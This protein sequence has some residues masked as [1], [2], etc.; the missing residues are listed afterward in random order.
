LSGLQTFSNIPQAADLIEI[1]NGN[2]GLS[3]LLIL[4]N[5][6]PFLEY[7]M[8]NGQ[9]LAVNVGKA[10]KPGNNNTIMLIGIGFSPGSTAAVDIS[11]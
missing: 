5:D 8:T 3:D 1:T 10:M 9:N 4:V 6:V 2:P 11:Q 7:K